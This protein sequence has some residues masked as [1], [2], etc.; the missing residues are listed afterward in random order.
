MT[1]SSKPATP[2]PKKKGNGTFF[3]FVLVLVGLAGAVGFGVGFTQTFVPVQGGATAFLGPGLKHQYFIHTS[4]STQVPYSVTVSV[5][6]HRLPEVAS[7]GKIVP[8]TDFV[9][10]GRNKVMFEA[11]KLPA[12]MYDKDIGWIDVSVVEGTA[13]NDGYKDGQDLVKYQRKASE[14]GDF[15]DEMDWEPVNE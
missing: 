4:G 8:I 1:D 11:K 6:G 7:G 13:T 5:N 3:I 15:K 9:I 2:P 12:G 14:Q 10:K